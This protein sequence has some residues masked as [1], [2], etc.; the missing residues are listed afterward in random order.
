MNINKNKLIPDVNVNFI[1]INLQ[2]LPNCTKFYIML[3]STH[4][5][6][7]IR[8]NFFLNNKIHNEVILNT[9]MLN[10]GSTQYSSFAI[11]LTELSYNI[12]FK[13]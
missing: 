13:I 8:Y 10:K 6:T 2:N 11:H 1:K 12:K 7:F 4:K 3:F 9:D 5:T